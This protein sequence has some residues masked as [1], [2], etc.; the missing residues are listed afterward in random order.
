MHYEIQFKGTDKEKTDAAWDE[1]LSYLG[2]RNTPML[3]GVREQVSATTETVDGIVNMIG[4]MWGI[5]GHFPRLALKQFLL[6]ER[7]A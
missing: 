3:E 2:E 5:Q 7:E 4:M 1:V 6:G